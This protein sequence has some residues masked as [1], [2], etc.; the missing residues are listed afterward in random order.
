MST[1]KEVI[2]IS[3]TSVYPLNNN[4]VTEQTPVKDTPLAKIEQL[5]LANQTFSTTILRF[6][7]LYGYDRK[8]GHFFKTNKLIKQ[9][10][11][12][13]NFIHRDDCINI[14]KQLIEKGVTQNV[15]N[16]CSDSHP[17]RREF[18]TH[19]FKKVGRQTPIFDEDTKL[20]YKIINSEKLK[21]F[22]NYTFKH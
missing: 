10:E 20:E 19:A 4:I 8:P 2:F 14:L 17:S 22:L 15:F 12:F 9:P 7:G 6:G 16:A 11:G 3:S 1:I 21:R 18:Y 5:F 13:I